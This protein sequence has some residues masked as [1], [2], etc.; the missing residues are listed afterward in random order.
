M[1]NSKKKI[2]VKNANEISAGHLH[3]IH[4]FLVLAV[5]FQF[6]VQI[7]TGKLSEGK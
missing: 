2:R 5:Q 6:V 7:R 1:K 3:V 4:E